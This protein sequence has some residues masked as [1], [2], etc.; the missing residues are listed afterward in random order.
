MVV[1]KKMIKRERDLILS[2]ALIC[3]FLKTEAE[4][5]GVSMKEY[6][7]RFLE[8]FYNEPSKLPILKTRILK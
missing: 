2:D 8:V 4:K 1:T 6:V 3:S 5:A 7:D